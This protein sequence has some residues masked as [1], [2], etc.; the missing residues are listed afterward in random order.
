MREL[1]LQKIKIAY[2]NPEVTS[3]GRRG[4]GEKV[5]TEPS[6]RAETIR[7]HLHKTKHLKWMNFLN[8]RKE[9]YLERGGE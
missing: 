4:R 1:P 7:K 2:E 5:V 6:N 8:K 9:E 3:N